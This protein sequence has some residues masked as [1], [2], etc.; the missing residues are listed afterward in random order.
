L[1]QLQQHQQHQ[2]RRRN[3]GGT[4]RTAEA[5]E[6]T[7][8]AEAAEAFGPTAMHRH[9]PLGVASALIDLRRLEP[10]SG[11]LVVAK[12]TK[13][14][15]QL[16]R[17]PKDNRGGEEGGEWGYE[18]RC[19]VWSRT[20]AA[21]TAV[22]AAAASA[23]GASSSSSSSTSITSSSAS[24]TTTSTAA[25]VAAPPPPSPPADLYTTHLCCL[26]PVQQECIA[27]YGEMLED[28]GKAV[29]FS[30]AERKRGAGEGGCM[31]I[32]RNTTSQRL[33]YMILF[34]LG[35]GQHHHRPTL[36][37][38]T[39]CRRPSAIDHST[40]T[41]PANSV[42]LLTLSF[43]HLPPRALNCFTI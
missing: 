28:E 27:A 19:T 23:F 36:P 15:K 37:P 4:A 24:T 13:Q 41:L 30:P 18:V 25:A 7:E 43:D 14:Q 40:Q 34:L 11:G 39:I 29:P 35:L 2:Q 17:P 31:Y 33:P 8:A 5:A 6:A 20:A 10:G 22:A 3:G 12:A 38:S 26:R 32:C 1:Q 9:P 21:P 16:Q 42:A